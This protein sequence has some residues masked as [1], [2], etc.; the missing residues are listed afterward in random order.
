MSVPVDIVKVS[1]LDPLVILAVCVPTGSPVNVPVWVAAAVPFGIEKFGDWSTAP[2][3]TGELLR[4]G[5]VLTVPN[6]LL[7]IAIWY[8]GAAAVVPQT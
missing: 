6:A 7:L 3:V 1:T 2:I 5:P 8:S 4:D